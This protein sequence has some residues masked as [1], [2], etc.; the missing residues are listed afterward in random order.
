MQADA[1]EPRQTSGQSAVGSAQAVDPP[2]ELRPTQPPP[3][4]GLPVPGLPD[5]TSLDVDSGEDGLAPEELDALLQAEPTRTGSIRPGSRCAGRIVTIDES[6]VIVSFGAKVEGHVPLEEFRDAGG[7]IVAEP[8]QQV[9]VIVE[10][11]GAPGSYAVLSYRRARE[12]TAWK[13]LETS[14]AERLPIQARVVG[15]VKGGLRVDIGVAAFLPGSH[16][17]IRPVRD[18]DAW[19]GKTIEVLVIECNR[20]RSNAVV[21]RSELLKAELQMR[22]Q[23]TL[24]QLRVGEPATGVVKNVTTYGVFVDLGGIDGLIKLKELSY[25]RVGSPG[26]LLR[27]GQ[28]VTAKV[29]RIDPSKERVALSLRDM[30]PDPWLTISERYQVGAGVRGRVAS[31][32]DYGA[33]VELEPGVE[34]LIHITEIDWSRRP[35]HPSKTFAVGS[36]TETVV[37]SVSPGERRISLSFKRLTPDP[38]DQYGASLEIGQVVAGIVRRVT[39]YGVFVEIVE[40]LEGLVHISDLSWDTRTKNP[41]DLVRKGQQI[42]TVVL[43][44]DT[45]NRRLSLGVKQLE[46]DVWDT[47]LS[48]NAVGDIVPGTVLRIV[49]FGLFVE[50]APAVEGLCHNSQAPRPLG[51][52]TSALEVGQRYEFEILD[53]N[54]RGRRIGLRCE[55]AVALRDEES[56]ST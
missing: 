19:I 49:K 21:S 4:P 7:E 18:L 17:D 40:G 39:T 16:L 29:L 54:E 22:Q 24:S 36:E 28:Q 51:R 47:F 2:F 53:V 45:E 25:G 8:G 37:L 35:K 34:G 30:Q 26:D 27:A 33:F 14:Y 3:V 5:S 10:R 20:R 6:G 42:N 50:L 23:E 48:Q 15:R 41:R 9:E 1:D 46:P 32:Q 52:G 11:L 13:Q 43:H 31:V 55:K 56:E 12:S 38:W 44:V